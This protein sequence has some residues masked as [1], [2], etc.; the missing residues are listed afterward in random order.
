MRPF[1]ALSRLVGL[2]LA[3]IHIYLS[4]RLVKV[5]L[6]VAKTEQ[7]GNVR[8][9]MQFMNMA[10]ASTIVVYLQW[11][12]LLNVAGIGVNLYLLISLDSVVNDVCLA[13][14]SF[15]APDADLSDAK[16]VGTAEHALAIGR[17]DAEAS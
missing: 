17:G 11:M 8:R 10:V 16:R 2:I 3:A 5:L 4:V 9:L 14:L 15:S 6:F 1:F 13:F 7:H 12:S